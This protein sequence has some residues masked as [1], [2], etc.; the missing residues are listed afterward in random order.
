M[1]NTRCAECEMMSIPRRADRT[2]KNKHLAQ[3]RGRCVCKH[4][5]AEIALE[6]ILPNSRHV[7]RFICFTIGGSDTP[8]MKTSPIWCPKRLMREPRHVLF[9]EAKAIIQSHRPHGM[10]WYFSKKQDRFIGIDSRTDDIWIGEFR[11]KDAC[12]KGLKR[13]VKEGST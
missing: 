1:D 13:R 7:K 2:R 11:T 5:D 3:P 9:R 6:L 8:T 10:Y 4:P 12:I